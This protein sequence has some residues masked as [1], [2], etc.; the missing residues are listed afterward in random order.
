[1]YEASVTPIRIDWHDR[2]ARF[3][4]QANRATI[5]PLAVMTSK[6]RSA[7]HASAVE[8]VDV[9]ALAFARAGHAE[10]TFGT[11]SA[12]LG[13]GQMATIA[14]PST[15]PSYRLEAGYHGTQVIIPRAIIETA[16]TTLSG[17]RPKRPLCFEPLLHFSPGVGISILSIINLFI[18]DLDHGGKM[19][20]SSI[21]INRLV[22]ALSYTL[23]LSHPHNYS[24]ASHPKPRPI[25]RTYVRQVEEYLEAHAD[26]PISLA[27]LVA[28]TGV[29]GRSLQTG[30]RAQHG[31]SPMQF[32]RERRLELAHK[33]ILSREG[34]STTQIA[35]DCGF[36]HLGRFSLEYRARFGE[37]PSHTIRRIGSSAGEDATPKPTHPGRSRRSG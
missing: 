29:S 4:W 26:Q 10:V 3:E 32:L 13:P 16:F 9:Y 18:G 27:D 33:R 1:M 2:R 7:V 37:S 15:A 20:G 11:R 24:G 34:R 22:D 25:A 8:S 23:L 14:S 17:F 6:Y 19:L 5:G 12:Q 21:I 28:L 36:E 30:F 31:C 35:L